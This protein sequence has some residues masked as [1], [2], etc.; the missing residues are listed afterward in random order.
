MFGVLGTV[1]GWG[2]RGGIVKER[3]SDRKFKVT[4]GFYPSRFR[5]TRP[6]LEN[7]GAAW[8]RRLQQLDGPPSL[9][10]FNQ[11]KTKQT[12]KKEGKREM[13]KVEAD[14]AR[15]VEVKS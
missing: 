11:S 10:G 3:N 12:K 1:Q 5:A 2:W 4:P 8:R 9:T 13:V 6:T 14:K 15:E 7:P